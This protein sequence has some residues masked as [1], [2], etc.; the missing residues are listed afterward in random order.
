[1]GHEEGESPQEKLV[2]TET[3][4][5]AAARVGPEAGKDLSSLPSAAASSA[6]GCPMPGGY[7]LLRM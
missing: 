6:R 5:R 3:G 1:M 4:G 2:L 7:D